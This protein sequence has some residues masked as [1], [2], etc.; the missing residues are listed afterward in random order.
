MECPSSY[1]YEY[2]LGWRPENPNLHLE[3]GKAWHFAM[4]HL[5]LEAIIAKQ[6]NEAYQLF[7]EHYRQFTSLKLWMREMRLRI[8]LML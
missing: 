6:S 5:I 7:L 2:I 1:F 8:L 3:F 4:E